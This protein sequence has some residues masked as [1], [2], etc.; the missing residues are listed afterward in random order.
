MK[1]GAIAVGGFV[2]AAAP[3]GA[4]AQTRPTKH[5]AHAHGLDPIDADATA[6][7]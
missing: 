1:A 2:V 5:P 6:S 7:D 4:A 3:F